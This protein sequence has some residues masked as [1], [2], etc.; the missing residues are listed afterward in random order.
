M[1]HIIHDI[2]TY[3]ILADRT[4]FQGRG[5]EIVI[6][7][8]EQGV[9]RVSYC[10]EGKE[11]DF[12]SKEASEFITQGKKF[13][14]WT[15]CITDVGVYYEI[16]IC[17]DIVIK[18]EKSN[19]ILS[20]LDGDD[21]LH[22]GHIGSS[23][24]VVPEYPA[25]LI[26]NGKSSLTRFNLPIHSEDEFYGLGDKSGY[27]DRRGRRFSMGN[28]DSLGY[29]A[30]NSDPLYKSVPFFIKVNRTKSFCL[31]V[32]FPIAGIRTMDFG[33][34]SPYYYMVEADGGP[35][36]YCLFVGEHYGEVVSLYCKLTGHPML[37]PLYSFGFLGSSMNYLEPNDAPKRV[38]EYFE[39]IEKENIPCEGM[40]FSSG[41]LKASDGK[42]Y[43]F[44][45]NEE[46]FPDYGSYMRKLADRGYNIIM[47]LKPGILCS[48]PLYRWLDERG[49]FIK[50]Q[51]ERT[52]IEYFW[53]GA[54]SFIDF[55]N[56]MA[57]DWWKDCIKQSYLD[58][59]CA[60][61]WNDNNE[62]ELE[63]SELPIYKTRSQYPALM[64]QASWEAIK[65]KEPELRPWIYSRAGSTGLQRY[66]RT[67]T[68]DNVSDF[69]AL[70]YNQYMGISLGLSGMPFYGHDLGGFYGDFP[71]EELL[72]RSCETAVFQPRFV[73]HSWREN[74]VPT[75]PWSYP[76]ALERIKQLINAHYY[77]M[78]YIYDCAFQ[79]AL[80]GYPMERMLRLE[81]PHDAALS[82]QDPNML[83]GPFVLKVQAVDPQLDSVIVRL[84]A[85]VDWYDPREGR[86]H[87]GGQI[88]NKPVPIDG[89]PHI[90]IRLGAVIPTSPQILQ[91]STAM[92]E[93][94]DTFLY[95]NS[96]GGKTSYDHFEDDGRTDLSLG[97]YNHFRFEM[98]NGCVEIVCVKRGIMATEKKRCHRLLLPEGF[99][100]V[101]TNNNEFKFSP[102]ALELNVPMKLSIS[103]TWVTS[104]YQC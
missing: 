98:E 86:V 47:N 10:F 75:E 37:G 64:C 55:S 39:R 50:D 22:G 84:P 16:S 81:F 29:D 34:E 76:E 93:Q 99:V 26:S 59:G 67:W 7:F 56:Q 73:I 30:S 12:R 102:E 21:V 31:G 95:P 57:K 1:K 45:W 94:L 80:T 54:A 79:A 71:Q 46:K 69:V 8:Y 60:G 92:F 27:P 58:H 97:R 85:D 82:S 38:L 91:L 74:G 3:H 77:Y 36:D 72:L 41:Y 66:A 28:R 24:L 100:F 87:K 6:G 88:I 78:P 65:E 14:P 48:H 25:R 4:V 62:L 43:A 42:R 13:I 11:D 19:G 68:G 63:D 70:R 90:M 23:D 9:I 33:K 44:I 96:L 101:D 15:Y 17:S 20:L 2:D 35:C 83:F 61:I 49:Y 89:K 51:D 40:Y 53:G 18:I 104:I 103:G 5:G 52:Y 32:L